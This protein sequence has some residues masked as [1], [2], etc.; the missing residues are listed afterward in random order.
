[1]D[2]FSLCFPWKVPDLLTHPRVCTQAVSVIL[3][4][5]KDALL[6][7]TQLQSLQSLVGLITCLIL[8]P[9]VL[10]DGQDCERD[11]GNLPTW[12]LSLV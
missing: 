4:H 7:W 8:Q 10:M 2:S 11:R 6:A 3:G 9:P 5:L 12:M 1:M